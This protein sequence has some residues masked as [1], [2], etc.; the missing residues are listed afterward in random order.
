[1]GLEFRRVLFRSD[2]ENVLIEYLQN[3]LHADKSDKD[4]I[5]KTSQDIADDLSTMVELSVNQVSL[6]LLELGYHTQITEDGLP[7]WA[8]MKR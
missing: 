6:T 5:Y 8:I 2:L 7:K 3:F 1:M 4:V